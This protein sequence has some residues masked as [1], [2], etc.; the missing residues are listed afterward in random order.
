MQVRP[1]DRIGQSVQRGP[2]AADDLAY[3]DIGYAS[4][5]PDPHAIDV[6]AED[7]S[8][9]VRTMSVEVCHVQWVTTHEVAWRDSN[10]RILERR[11]TPAQASVQD[12]DLDALSGTRAVGS[13]DRLDA[14]GGRIAALDRQR[15]TE[16]GS[17]PRR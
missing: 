6:S 3:Q 5:N 15:H 7:D 10:V 9:T 2:L 4:R 13:A 17:L 8:S 16:A 12:R 1:V 14:P 11:V